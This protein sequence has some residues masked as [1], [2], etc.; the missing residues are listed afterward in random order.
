MATGDGEEKRCA[1]FSGLVSDLMVD[2]MKRNDWV[3][4]DSVEK[5]CVCELPIYPAPSKNLLV[6]VSDL[7]SLEMNKR[8][9]IFFL[10]PGVS[11]ECF[12]FLVT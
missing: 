1:I 10:N 5:I 12:F 7:E 2:F 3:G 11:R 8:D 6:S 9:A 4:E